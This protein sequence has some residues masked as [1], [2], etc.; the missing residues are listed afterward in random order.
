MN[1]LNNYIYILICIFGILIIGTLLYIL[2]CIQ[3]HYNECF[4]TAITYTSSSLIYTP[5]ISN[6]SWINNALDSNIQVVYDTYNSIK[7][8]SI[9]TLINANNPRKLVDLYS[10]TWVNP[11]LYEFTK[12]GILIDTDK[13][14][15]IRTTLQYTSINAP[16]GYFVAFTSPQVAMRFTCSLDLAGRNIGY[17]GYMDEIF[18]DS[19]LNGHR[20]PQESVT[21]KLFN[22]S[23]LNVLNVFIDK[24]LVDIFITYIVPG[25]DF[26]KTLLKQRV[27][28]L[29]FIDMDIAR[30]TLFYPGL[31]MQND[32]NI[33]KTLLDLPSPN[34]TTE[35]TA[36]VTEK[37]NITNLPTISQQLLL[38]TPSKLV[39]TFITRLNLPDTY[40]DPTYVCYGD[41][42]ENIKALCDS[43]YDILGASKKRT[44]TWDHPCIVD[45]D[46]PYYKANTNY[47]NIRGGCTDSGVCELPIGVK[48]VSFRKYEDTGIY[49]PYCYG[50]DAYDTNCCDR[51]QNPDYAFANDTDARNNAKLKLPT[52]IPRSS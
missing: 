1:V 39:E 6:S 51:Q 42:T 7:W 30:V 38:F 31:T 28:F 43:S 2:I 8:N 36:T 17:F 40:L 13:V 15:Q 11:I 50:C 12:I 29:G 9:K 41:T 32:V 21:K 34:N 33:R 47:P 22:E 23:Q 45:T 4:S 19:V 20:I 24:N 44:T 52:S 16:Q 46:C 18:I 48:R 5:H 37:E 26:H 35:N 25:S 27:T 3:R 10:N 14:K 49:A